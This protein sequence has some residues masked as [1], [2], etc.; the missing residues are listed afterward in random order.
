MGLVGFSM[1]RNLSSF[2]MVGITYV[3]INTISVFYGHVLFFLYPSLLLSWKFEHDCLHTYCF[4]SYMY[5]F[6]TFVLALAKCI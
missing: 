2:C 1:R 5:V 6:G 3:Y 4:G